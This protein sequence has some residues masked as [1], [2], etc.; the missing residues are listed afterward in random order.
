MNRAFRF[1]LVPLFF[2]LAA[3]LPA[4]G[5]KE[6]ASVPTAE[7]NNAAMQ[8]ENSAL[9]QVS[10]RVRLVGNEPFSE[11]VITGSDR[12]WYIDKED[13]SKLRDLQHRTVT[14][15]GTETVEQLTYANGR[16]A[17]ERRTLKNIRIVA[18]Q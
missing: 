1:A 11:L 14:V 12:E 18:V 3:A 7:N 4:W 8:K 9:M 2:C 10:G 15:E 16:S 5:K 13:E 17:G 6:A